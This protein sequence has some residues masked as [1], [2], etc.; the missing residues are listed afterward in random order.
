[1]LG[2]NLKAMSKEHP[3]CSISQRSLFVIYDPLLM[4][5]RKEKAVAIHNPE[6]GEECLENSMAA[7]R[8]SHDIQNA[9]RHG[10]WQP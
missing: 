9:I 1:M 10:V 6:R 8:E 3:R 4:D 5:T 7:P 2:S